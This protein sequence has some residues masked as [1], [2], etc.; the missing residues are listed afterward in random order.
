MAPVH[1]VVLL[2]NFE[3][4]ELAQPGQPVMTLGDPESLWVRVYVAA[5]QI[6][7]VRLGAH[8]EVLA[9][10]FG[11][12]TFAGRVTT[13]ATQAEFTPR[14]ALTEEER[15]NLVFAVKIALDPT[16]GALKAGLPV[17]VRI[18]AAEPDR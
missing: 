4:G 18:A 2:R 1:G 17:D 3:T 11:K 7:R 15:A 5:P 13:I 8:A 10:G 9:D 14:A 16:G 12:R 6:G